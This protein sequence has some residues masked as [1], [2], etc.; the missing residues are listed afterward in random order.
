M[1]MQLPAASGET[2]QAGSQRWTAL[3]LGM[4]APRHQIAAL[5]SSAAIRVVRVIVQPATVL[6][7]RSLRRDIQVEAARAFFGRET[8]TPMEQDIFE[9]L[10]AVSKRSFDIISNHWTSRTSI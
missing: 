1:A 6:G 5:N 7:R 3:V 4:V 2:P 9:K 8:R 10:S